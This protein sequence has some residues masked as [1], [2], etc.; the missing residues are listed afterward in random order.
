M[1]EIKVSIIFFYNDNVTFKR[2]Q[3]IVIYNK[4][5]LKNDFNLKLRILFVK[6]YFSKSFDV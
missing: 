4:L 1:T 2:H 5:S 6:Q 3:T